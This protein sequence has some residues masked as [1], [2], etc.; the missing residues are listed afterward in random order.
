MSS[1]KKL[2]DQKNLNKEIEKE[3]SLEDQLI[4]IL[5]KRKGIDSDILSDQQDINNVIQDQVKQMKFQASEKKTKRKLKM[6]QPIVL[7]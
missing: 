4:R 2:D 3:I 6:L 5:A 7:E 1:K